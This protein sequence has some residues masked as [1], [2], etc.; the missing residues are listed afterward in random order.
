MRPGGTAGAR[1]CAP[2][3]RTVTLASVFAVVGAASH[4][5]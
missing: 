4:R 1:T 2:L 3:L 5:G